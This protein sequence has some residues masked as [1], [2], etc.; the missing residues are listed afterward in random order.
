[1]HLLQAGTPL[2]IIR[3]ILGHADLRRTELSARADLERQRRALAKAHH[4]GV[5][6]PIPSW[7][8][9]HD[10]LAWRRSL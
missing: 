5:T 2:G 1:M 3:A 4:P 7:Q 6:P 8:T 9:S 10:L